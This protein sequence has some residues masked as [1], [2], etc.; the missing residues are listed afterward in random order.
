MPGAWVADVAWTS[1]AGSR[2]PGPSRTRASV[3]K[4]SPPVDRELLERACGE[5]PAG[6]RRRT[7]DLRRLAPTVDRTRGDVGEGLSYELPDVARRCR[8]P[9]PPPL[10]GAT[11]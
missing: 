7:L 1:H 11:G 2:T 9:V 5:A 3:V 10:G 8:V 4:W 6:W